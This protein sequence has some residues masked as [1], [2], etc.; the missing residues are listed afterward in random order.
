[1]SQ[2]EIEKSSGGRGI[3]YEIDLTRPNAQPNG[4][5]SYGAMTFFRNKCPNGLSPELHLEPD[6]GSSSLRLAVARN[7]YLG[8]P[9]DD[10]L[11][12]DRCELRDSKLSLGTPVWYSTWMP[13][14]ARLRARLSQLLGAP[15]DSLALAPSVSA[16]LTTLASCIPRDPA[17]GRLKVLIGELDFP[18]PGPPVAVTGRA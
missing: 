5:I 1:M 9:G 16:A 13:L 18:H 2:A 10:A 14:L 15:A 12:N 17:A 3:D 4:D 6:G 7:A 11:K 8:V